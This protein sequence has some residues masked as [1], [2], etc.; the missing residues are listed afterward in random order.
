MAN[1]PVEKQTAG[2]LSEV[3][4]CK[5]CSNHETVADIAKK[6]LKDIGKEPPDIC[7]EMQLAPVENMAATRIA[8]SPI[9]CMMTHWD[10]CSRCGFKYARRTEL[11]QVPEQVVMAALG[12]HIQP[13]P[14]R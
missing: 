3:K 5:L 13:Q 1:N 8:G 12:V 4:Q 7:S 11:L 14:R 9:W 6:R 2:V 10:V